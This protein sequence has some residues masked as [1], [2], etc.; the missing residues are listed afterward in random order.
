[1]L[2]FLQCVR[3]YGSVSYATRVLD[4]DMSY[5]D[6]GD[7]VC[8]VSLVHRQIGEY[9]ED[10]DDRESMTLEEKEE[11]HVLWGMLDDCLLIQERM[12][13]YKLSRRAS[14]LRQWDIDVNRRFSSGMTAVDCQMCVPYGVDRPCVGVAGGCISCLA[15]EWLPSRDRLHHVCYM[16]ET[17]A[18]QATHRANLERR[19]FAVEHNQV[20]EGRMAVGGPYVQFNRLAPVELIVPEQMAVEHD[21]DDDDDGYDD[22][23]QHMSSDSEEIEDDIDDEND[24]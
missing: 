20:L 3:A 16:Y 24:G 5:A 21:D 19:L 17:Q 10:L 6:F 22:D 7:Q 11:R 14:A 9:V 15:A 12:A 18:Q 8:R 23:D 13:E 2:S 4:E 1:M